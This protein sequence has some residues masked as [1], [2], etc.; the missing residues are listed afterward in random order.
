MRRIGCL[1]GVFLI[2]FSFVAMAVLV[3]IPVLPF[4]ENNPTLMAIKGALLCAP[5]QNYVMEGR[6]FS[7]VRG[8]GRTFQVYCVKEDG[9]KINVMDKDFLVSIIAFVVPFLIGLFLI[10]SLS[11]SAAQR[12]ARRAMQGVPS[13]K[14][15]DKGVISVGGMQ[16]RV[17][18]G[19]SASSAG[20]EFFHAQKQPLDLAGKLEQIEE[21]RTKG[22]ITQDEY[23]RMRKHILDENM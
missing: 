15:T 14:L 11:V 18:P 6:N 4:G 8:S 17:Q 2:V 5:G 19:M 9:T 13:A 3:V 22:L 1:L 16:I 21:A 12:Q 23:D 7:D 10:I 20:S